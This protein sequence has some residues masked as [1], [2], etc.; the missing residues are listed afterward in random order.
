MEVDVVGAC[1]ELIT[2][3]DASSPKS[4]K[5]VNL[6]INDTDNQSISSFDDDGSE[7]AHAASCLHHSSSF[8]VPL[9]IIASIQSLA[10]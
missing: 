3:I 2:I 5:C 9:A 10:S 4:N 7:S 1:P 6:L 8:S